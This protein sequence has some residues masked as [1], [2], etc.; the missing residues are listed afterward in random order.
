MVSLGATRGSHDTDPVGPSPLG[1]FQASWEGGIHTQSVRGQVSCPFLSY[2]SFLNPGLPD[3][4][5]HSVPQIRLS[6]FFLC[7][8]LLGQGWPTGHWS[9]SAVVSHAQ[10]ELLKQVENFHQ[11]G[12]GGPGPDPQATWSSLDS[13]SVGGMD[14]RG[15]RSHGES[16]GLSVSWSHLLVR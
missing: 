5:A 16:P 6:S 7:S 9:P 15:A 3:P 12:P 8:L 14:G 13:G 11:Q 10:Q 4:E 2:C 1:T